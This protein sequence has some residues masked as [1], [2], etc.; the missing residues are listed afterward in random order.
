VSHP[1]WQRGKQIEEII[2]LKHKVIFAS[3]EE[4]AKR[5]AKELLESSPRKESEVKSLAASGRELADKLLLRWNPLYDFF[6]KELDNRISELKQTG[7]IT[8]SEQIQAELLVVD[9]ESR[10]VPIRRITF[11]GN[12]ERF[13]IMV[14]LFQGQI[15]RGNLVKPPHLQFEEHVNW[16]SYMPVSLIFRAEAISF[17][18]RT[19]IPQPTQIKEY[20][21]MGEDPLSDQEFRRALSTAIGNSLSFV[22]LNV[23]ASR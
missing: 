19:E 9:S 13:S 7:L 14:Y 16:A 10:A 8:D 11:L 18:H 12:L 3:S 2:A 23:A 17:E 22:Y 6:Q 4:D 15:H 5:W 1:H 21:A 20:K